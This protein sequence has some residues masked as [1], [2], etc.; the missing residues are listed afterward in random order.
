MLLKRQIA[1]D[2]YED[3]E[4]GL[5]Q[6]HELAVSNFR[7]TLSDDGMNFDCMT[8]GTVTVMSSYVAKASTGD[9]SISVAVML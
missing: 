2:S 9:T 3:I 5:R 6:S 8:M 7:P 4:L 1:V